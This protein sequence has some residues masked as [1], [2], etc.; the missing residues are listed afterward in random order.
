MS[1]N[2]VPNRNTPKVSQYDTQLGVIPSTY[3]I[4]AFDL[5]NSEEITKSIIPIVKEFSMTEELFSPV[6]V[7]NIKIY[8]D[9]NFFEEMG[10]N[11]QE[12]VYLKIEIECLVSSDSKEENL[13]TRNGGIKV[14][15]K[16]YEYTFA[17]KEYPNYQK[18]INSQGVQEYNMICIPTYAYLSAL[19]RISRAI[20]G[21]VIDNIKNIF[22]NDLYLGKDSKDEKLEVVGNPMTQFEGIITIQSPLKAIEWLRSKLY[23]DISSPFFIYRPLRENKIFIHCLTNITEEE[24]YRVFRYIPFLQ[25]SA[26]NA[27]D[28]A[29]NRIYNLRGVVKMDKLA[30]ALGGGFS[31]KVQ[32]TNITKKS[33]TEKTLNYAE[34]IS[35]KITSKLNPLTS[36]IKSIVFLNNNNRSSS[37]SSNNKASLEDYA[38]ANTVNVQSNTS[39]DNSLSADD[40]IDNLILQ[41]SLISR[42]ESRNQE[43][44][45]NGDMHLNPGQKI[46]MQIGRMYNPKRKEKS[47]E[48]DT[49]YAQD[50]IDEFLSG[51]YIIGI[52]AHTFKEGLYRTRLKVFND[53]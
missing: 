35:K 47:D 16:T 7:L 32:L 29:Y 12:K 27:S 33:V 5:T 15:K 6:N 44:E 51:I 37:G 49:Q 34:S 18:D 10:L 22:T 42:L 3:S 1:T 39:A 45:V 31:S 14:R 4:K 36:Y 23:D 11:G 28:E 43:I 48:L 26:Q 13:E 9:I 41:Q 20:T 24:K 19:S 25:K 52:A 38:D 8:D 40:V 17:V 21:P 46:D 53:I 30:Q 50:D 2:S